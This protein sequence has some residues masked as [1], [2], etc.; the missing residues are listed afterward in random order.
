MESIAVTV[1]RL[2]LLIISLVHV[3]LFKLLEF[4]PISSC[5]NNLFIPC[6]SLKW[7]ITLQ[8]AIVQSVYL[9]G[10][11]QCTVD[12]FAVQPITFTIVMP[13]LRMRSKVYGSVFVCL[14]RLLQ[15]P[16]DKISFCRFVC[17]F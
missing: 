16:N 4:V 5:Q 12:I 9:R 14:C 15:L 7:I 17:C 6:L 10:L 2:C 8:F 1:V 3:H 11:L 13:R